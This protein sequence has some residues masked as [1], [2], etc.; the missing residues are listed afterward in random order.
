M[1]KLKSY[2][3]LFKLNVL[4]YRANHSIADTARKYNIDR[5]MVRDWESHRN[6]LLTQSMKAK[7]RRIVR[8]AAGRWSEFEDQVLEWLNQLREQGRCVS[9]RMVQ[10]AH[11]PSLEFRAS[12]GWLFNFLKRKRLVRRR[13]TTSG[14]DLNREAPQLCAD[15]LRR[16]AINRQPNFNRR[17]LLNM[18]QTSIY[19]DTSSKA[20]F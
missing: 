16:C 3:I 1:A 11:S 17:C 6:E 10:V 9:G 13:V 5:K 18:D 4:N 7:R 20:V 2:S 15:F 14:R 8:S 12:N 19:M